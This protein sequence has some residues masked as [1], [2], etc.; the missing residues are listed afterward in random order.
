MFIP[1]KLACINHYDTTTTYGQNGRP[2]VRL[3][4][5]KHE[6]NFYS[7]SQEWLPDIGGSFR[8]A[9]RQFLGNENKLSRN[10]EA[11]TQYTKF[12]Q[13]MIETGHLEPVPDSDPR[14]T[15]SCH[16]KQYGNQALR[17]QN[18]EQFS[19]YQQKQRTEEASTIASCLVQKNCP[20]F[21]RY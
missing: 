20:T 18:A 6:N 10:A 17:L 11:Q 7:N 12:F 19:T 5:Y 13:E 9:V 16:I 1:K 2:E 14:N 8:K 21:L 4:I 3:P 15:L